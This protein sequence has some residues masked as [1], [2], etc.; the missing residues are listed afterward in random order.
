MGLDSVEFVMAV[1]EDFQISIE[2]DEAETIATVGD[3]QAVILRK[4]K[5]NDADLE[6]TFVWAKLK[7]IVVDELGVRPDQVTP[8][9]RFIQD[10]RID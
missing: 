9:A 10:F 7:Q 4:L 6:E 5:E 3:M 2:N 1:E 8:E